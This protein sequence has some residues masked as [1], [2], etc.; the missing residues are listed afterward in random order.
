VTCCGLS[1]PNGRRPKSAHRS[2]TANP[3]AAAIASSSR[4]GA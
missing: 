2:A 4:G 3:A 1:S